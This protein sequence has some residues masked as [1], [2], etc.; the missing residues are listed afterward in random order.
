MMLVLDPPLLLDFHD[1]HV[2][3]LAFLWPSIFV[4]RVMVMTI[5]LLLDFCDCVI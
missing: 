4:S 1:L 5:D 2:G 3:A